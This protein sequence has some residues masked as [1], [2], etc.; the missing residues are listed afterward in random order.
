MFYLVDPNTCTLSLAKQVFCKDGCAYHA[1]V[2]HKD[3]IYWCFHTDV[4]RINPYTQGRSNIAFLE[5]PEMF[6]SESTNNGNL[7]NFDSYFH[8]YSKGCITSSANIWQ[9]SAVNYHYQIP[10]SDFSGYD[11]I[12]IT[13]NSKNKAYIAFFASY[14][15][16]T[17]AIDYAEGWEKQVIIEPGISQS[18]EI[19][20]NAKYL[21]I[22]N[23]NAAGNNLIPESVIFGYKNLVF[24]DIN[25]DGKVNTIDANYARRYAAGLLT[26]DERQ[27]LAADVSGDGEINVMDS[28][29]IRRY[30]VKYIDV[31]PAEEK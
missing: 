1:T 25:L 2:Q 23:N 16:K 29:L 28:S 7:L 10:L 18:F 22:L 13:A 12:T 19:P 26:L 21:Y 20:K 6:I 4:R 30:V 24:G 27:K 5:L 17:G 8:M 11:K 14:I 3:K 9:S 31:F 15:S